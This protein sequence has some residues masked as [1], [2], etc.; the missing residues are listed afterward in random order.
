MN[1][2]EAASVIG[3]ALLTRSLGMPSEEVELLLMT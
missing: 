1:A 2:L 3:L